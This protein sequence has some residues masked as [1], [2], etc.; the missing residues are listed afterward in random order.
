MNKVPLHEKY[1]QAKSDDLRAAQKRL[2]L[3][4]GSRSKG[5]GAF[6]PWRARTNAHH[7]CA[8]ERVARSLSAD[9]LGGA[10]S[11][12]STAAATPQSLRPTTPATSGL[13]E[14]WRRNTCLVVYTSHWRLLCWP[15]AF[16]CTHKKPLSAR[17]IRRPCS[18]AATRRSIR[19]SR[20]PTTS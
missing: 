20:P 4:G 15:A 16:R 10:L 11:T 7:P 17:A 3:T 1:A 13:S 18:T 9:P 5:N 8:G 14:P 6:V 12:S 2:K 19:I